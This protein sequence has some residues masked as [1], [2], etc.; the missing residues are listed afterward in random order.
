MCEHIKSTI[1]QDV[2]LT[3]KL[4]VMMH[5]YDAEQEEG[6]CAKAL[7]D[8]LCN[9]QPKSLIGACKVWIN[10]GIDL[11]LLDFPRSSALILTPFIPGP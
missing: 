11:I 6:Q 10:T 2:G 3:V 8:G 1:S 4:G 5:C 7:A 9:T